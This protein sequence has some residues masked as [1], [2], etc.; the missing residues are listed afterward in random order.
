M[1]AFKHGELLAKS[2]VLQQQASASAENARE[3]PEP[4]PEQV[5]HDGKVITDGIL[6]PAP[7]LLISKLD[8]IVA[9]DTFLSPQSAGDLSAEDLVMQV[10]PAAAITL[11]PERADLLTHHH[12]PPPAS[13][14]GQRPAD[15][16]ND[17]TSPAHPECKWFRY[18]AGRSWHCRS[19][20]R[21]RLSQRPLHDR[22]SRR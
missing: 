8:G 14:K 17:G 13:R 22:R 18:S 6:V 10:G 12:P 15:A 2:Q 5:D 7:M 16:S 11:L 21:L 4:K 19:P 9:N 20:H 1:L 3:C